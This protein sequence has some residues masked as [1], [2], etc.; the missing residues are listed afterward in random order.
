MNETEP[1]KYPAVNKK[2]I[3]PEDLGDKYIPAGEH[4]EKLTYMPRIGE[5]PTFA[6]FFTEDL[7]GDLR[8]LPL[9]SIVR[10]FSDFLAPEQIALLLEH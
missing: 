7:G 8:P 6:R 1:S 4:P 5:E 3:V 2:L 9:R 10:I